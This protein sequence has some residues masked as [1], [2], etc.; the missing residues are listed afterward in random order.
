MTP[1]R[2]GSRNFPTRP[3]VS[4]GR[5]RLPWLPPGVSA[6]MTMGPTTIQA[7]TRRLVAAGGAQCCRGN[8]PMTLHPPGLLPHPNGFPYVYNE[9]LF[10]VDRA[11]VPALAGPRLGVRA[12]VTVDLTRHVTA[13]SLPLQP[14]ASLRTDR[15]LVEVVSYPDR[16]TLV[17]RLARFPTLGNTD[18]PRLWFLWA[19][20]TGRVVTYAG[21]EWWWT[22]GVWREGFERPGWANGRTWVD[23]FAF[24]V[25]WGNVPATRLVV[26]EARDGGRMTTT[27]VA[28]T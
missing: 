27:L 7:G 3:C 25:G 9:H 19:D 14:G 13:G 28:P 5:S 20:A 4:M 8:G 16:S 11:D 2:A 23:R 18:D 21:S 15:Y 24:G 17:I 10:D 26:I 12:P 22:D 6:R 1:H